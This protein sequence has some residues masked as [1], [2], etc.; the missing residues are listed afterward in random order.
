M[1]TTTTLIAIIAAIALAVFAVQQR[2]ELAQ[3]DATIAELNAQLAAAKTLAAEQNATAEIASNATENIKRLTTERDDALAKLAAVPATPSVE[4]PAA[5]STESKASGFAK[6][7]SEMFKGEDGKKMLRSQ[8]EFGARMIY[9]DFIKS[10]DPATSET[11][12]SLLAERQTALA[13]AGMEV[14]SAADP[15][16]ASAK[17]AALKKEF[18]DKLRGIVGDK[19]MAEMADHE[20]TAGDRMM[21][22]QT[23][24]QFATAG[25]PLSAEQR[26]G[27]LN[28][29]QTERIKLPKSP[30]E[31]QDN[32]AEA[33]RAV[34][35]EKVVAAWLASE[36]QLNKNVVANASKVLTPDQV[37]IL[38]KSLKQM[39]EMKQFGIKMWQSQKK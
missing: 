26:T 5:A 38:E 31:N 17:V 32:P 14:M 25:A 7:L 11:V 18:D 27:I 34:S 22:A 8:S 9:S 20:R 35:D 1:K 33:M 10:L 19:K 6:G 21:F 23:E 36:E 39:M 37:L 28:L 15:A 2:A 16:A 12:M 30:L 3:R 4:K 24:S 29:I 13:I